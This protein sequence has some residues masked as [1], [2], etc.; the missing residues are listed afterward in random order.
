MS[1]SSHVDPDAQATVTDFIDY[2][3]HLPSD[4]RRSLALIEKLNDL[5][6]ASHDKVHT[7]AQQWS[8]RV[9]ATAASSAEK[10][11]ADL[12]AQISYQKELSRKY[13][14]A[15]LAEARRLDQEVARH[16]NLLKITSLKLDALALPPSRDP[17]PKPLSPQ[18]SRANENGG[19]KIKLRL[20][21]A[22]ASAGSGP[23][24]PRYRRMTIVPGEVLPP[25][26][27][28]SPTASSVSD[29]ESPSPPTSPRRPGRKTLKLPKAVRSEGA[30]ASALKK[31]KD[32]QPR[33]PNRP[34]TNVHSTVAGISTSNALLMLT[35]PPTSPVPGTRHAPWTRLTEWEM[36]RLRKRMK[37]NA[38]WTPSDTM[39][40]RE[41]HDA[42][43]GPENYVKAKQRAEETGEEL[44]DCDNLASRPLGEEV[45]PGEIPLGSKS[46][47]TN[48][49]MSLNVQKKHKKLLLAKEM[50][51]ELAK[52]AGRDIKL[53]KLTKG[54]VDRAR[55]EARLR[56]ETVDSELGLLGTRFRDL[57]SRP[58]EELPE[59]DRIVLKTPGRK[60]KRDHDKS[61]ET[62]LRSQLHSE[63]V[64]TPSSGSASKSKKRKTNATPSQD[65][66][67]SPLPTVTTT[68]KI[69]LAAPAPS[70][71]KSTTTTR[72]GSA[73]KAEPRRLSLVI[74]PPAPPSR[75]SSRNSTPTTDRPA[76]RHSPRLSGGHP[77]TETAK[78]RPRR[79]S[80]TPSTP[81][82]VTLANSRRKRPAPGPVT[83]PP[84]GNAISVGKREKRP[85]KK[86][87]SGRKAGEGTKDAADE[88]EID[89]D[90]PRYCLCNDVS[91]GTMVACE[92]SDVSVLAQ[93]T[94]PPANFLQCE[95]QWFHLEC[96][97]LAEIP[98]RRTKWWCPECS[99]KLGKS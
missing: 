73:S 49:G 86:G 19:P 27:P 50:A 8:S 71:G 96:V 68:T 10:V 23:P 11:A 45:K 1:A 83:N 12:R 30:E 64:V 22:R 48:K 60:R 3:E 20:D 2:T 59:K 15:S 54:Q 32:R 4:I 57:F 93:C 84:G 62:Q 24:H 74:K 87:S 85:G 99:V 52:E 55:E 41:L 21:K 16:Q 14:W 18:A 39:I 44:I 36:A 69:P 25:P 88:E 6:S 37:K 42:G 91:W 56:A 97:G 38:V 35:P 98:G 67:S 47:L 61:P 31:K 82:V 46:R 34:G 13:A 63:I 76:S 70:P 5:V 89:P 95:K 81:A 17:S 7:L 75:R 33:D 65:A 92:N 79:Q 90:E 66:G 51:L 94:A 53:G 40:R 80:A 78:E 72:S 43:R 29:W 77:S 9:V 28:N 58:G 26:N